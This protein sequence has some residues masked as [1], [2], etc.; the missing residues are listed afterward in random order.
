[1]LVNHGLHQMMERGKL[2]HKWS[3]DKYT[4]L[5]AREAN[6]LSGLA[7]I[8]VKVFFE[9][10]HPISLSAVFFEDYAM[11]KARQKND[12]A[13][14]SQVSIPRTI[15]MNALAEGVM[16]QFG[17]PFL[18]TWPVAMALQELTFDGNHYAPQ[19]VVGST[20]G[21]IIAHY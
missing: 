2:H 1:M 21:Q 3:L 18:N 13:D 4:N 16:K 20:L 7:D 8:G 9:S 11:L 15:E 14:Y 17:I 12:S 6:K 10:T 5:V 19:G